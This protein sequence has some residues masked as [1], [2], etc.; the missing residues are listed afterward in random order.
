[1]KVELVYFRGCPS[2]PVAREALR[3]VRFTEVAQDDLPEGDS[4]LGLSSPTLLV[5]GSVWAGGECGESACS[6][7]SWDSPELRL[8]L[9]KLARG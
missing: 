8:R 3:G 7:V 1:M 2:V 5:D 9:S 6:L 4:R